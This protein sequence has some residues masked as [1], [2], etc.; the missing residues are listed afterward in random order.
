M[1]NKAAVLTGPETIEMKEL[2]LSKPQKGE[3]TVKMQAVGICGSDVHYYRKGRIGDFIVEYPFIL[4]HESAGIVT[5]VGEG[6]STLKVGDRV[7]L[8][9]GV[10]C[11][12][13][14]YCLSGSYNLCPDV[15]F[16]ATPPY[17]G[18]LME[19]INYPAMWAFKIPDHMTYEE[20]A[21]V[22]PLAI[23]INAAKTAG[24]SLGDSVLVYG[25]GCIGLVSLMS[26]AAYGA[27][28]VYV[29]DMIDKRLEVAKRLGGIP[30][31]AG[32][33]DVAAEVLRLT[34]GRG[35]DKVLDCAGFSGTV[36][37]SINAC[38][39]GGSIVVVGM[40]EDSLNHVPL[41]PISTK[42]L[43]LTSIFR[44]KNLYP[45]AIAAIAGG[46][47]KV[48]GIVSNRYPFAE[49][50]HAY[51]DTVENIQNVVKGVIVFD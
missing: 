3:V 31:N 42:E 5:D 14:S 25:A 22:E 29:A 33:T 47:I 19:Y 21:L 16:L 12:K 41:T 38:R 23:G 46:K 43:K 13:C 24:V 6:V 32:K 36:A 35:V 49:T 15:K 28:T 37:G 7:A 39:A 44:Y 1:K 45:T 18:C 10:P 9:P 51:R 4:G 30:I 20:G 50:P 27:T 26:A 8:E 40:G 48:D 2:E 11:G 34:N 17:D